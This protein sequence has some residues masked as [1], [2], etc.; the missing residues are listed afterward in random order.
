MRSPRNAGAMSHET[1]PVANVEMA[2]AWDGDEGASWAAQAERYDAVGTVYN[3]HL[4]RH[5]SAPDRVLDIGCGNGDT[6]REAA[7][8]ARTVLGL[9]LSSAMLD[10]ARSRA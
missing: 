4:L 3:P 8:I 6:T 2:A 10:Y 7:R 5:I 9:D 1:P